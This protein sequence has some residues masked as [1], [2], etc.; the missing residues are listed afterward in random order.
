MWNPVFRQSDKY[1]VHRFTGSLKDREK[2]LGQKLQ[3]NKPVIDEW[4]TSDLV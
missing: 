1:C 2:F 3:N 4:N